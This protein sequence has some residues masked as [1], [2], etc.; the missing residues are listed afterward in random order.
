[1]YSLNAMR[2]KMEKYNF[3]QI[4]LVTI[5]LSQMLFASATCIAD[6][7]PQEISYR[8]Q[9]IVKLHSLKI[10]E[11]ASSPLVVKFVTEQNRKDMP[12]TEIKKIDKEWALGGKSKFVKSLQDNALGKFL[13]GKVESSILYVEAF[14]CDNKGAI[15]GLFPRTT[16]YWQGDE[17][18][19]IKSF[20][21]GKGRIYLSSPAFDESTQTYSVH[22]SVPIR[23]WN[24]TIGVL[25][26]G[27][28]NFQ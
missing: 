12:L 17:V 18:K 20:E 24:D 19:F 13:K 1:M 4:I 10:L 7:Q 21:N 28:Q 14:V 23:N 25:I 6:D 26:V 5:S 9:E 11:W 22:I 8:M 15:V 27:V 2:G 16:D 3:K